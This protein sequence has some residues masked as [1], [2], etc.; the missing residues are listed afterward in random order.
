MTQ[1][2]ITS[3]NT[4]G[5]ATN[6]LNSDT[7]KIPDLLTIL[8]FYNNNNE[9]L[10]QALDD[11]ASG[12]EIKNKAQFTNTL[13][14]LILIIQDNK[15]GNVSSNTE[16]IL[17]DTTVLLI[18]KE[19]LRMFKKLHTY[20]INRPM[21]KRLVTD[22]SRTIMDDFF[23][24]INEVSDEDLNNESILTSTLSTFNQK[25]EEV[26]SK[27]MTASGIRT[28]VIKQIFDFSN[29]GGN[30]NLPILNPVGIGAIEVDKFDNLSETFIGELFSNSS[31]GGKRRNKNKK[32]KKV[33][34]KNKKLNKKTK[35]NKS[36]RYRRY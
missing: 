11:M 34:R 27:N 23:S 16:S 14:A 17:N 8:N 32:T 13:K 6:I 25:F 2:I 31:Y 19:A 29:I 18:K 22:E 12:N 26:V 10:K 1:N 28:D 20:E 30:L 9:V 3:A 24:A 33:H 5:I 21:E 7:I 36:K 4:I 15:N 35:R